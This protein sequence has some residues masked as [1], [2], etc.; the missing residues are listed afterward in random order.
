MLLAFEHLKQPD[1]AG[2][3]YFLQNVDFLKH[4]PARVLILDR[5]LVDTLDR[6]FLT[7]QFVHAKRDFAEGAF[8]QQ[9]Y[10]LVEIE[11]CRRYLAVLLR[12]RLYVGYQVLALLSYWVV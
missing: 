5:G 6:H 4:F 9:L 11:S 1:H 10:E 8:A 12:I 3:P 7:S 2:M